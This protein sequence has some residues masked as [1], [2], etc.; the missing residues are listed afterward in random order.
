MMAE[1]AVVR[2]ALGLVSESG[3]GRSPADRAAGLR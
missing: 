3:A 1:L 2:A